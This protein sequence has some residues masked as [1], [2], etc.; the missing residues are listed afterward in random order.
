MFIHSMLCQRENDASHIHDV[1]S[2]GGEQHGGRDGTGLT[3]RM[4]DDDDD[5]S[6]DLQPPPNLPDGYDGRTT[7]FLTLWRTWTRVEG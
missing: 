6:I 5:D 2:A 3:I 7:A 4:A 1:S